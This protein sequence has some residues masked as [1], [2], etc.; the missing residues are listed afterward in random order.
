MSELTQNINVRMTHEMKKKIMDESYKRGISISAYILFLIQEHWERPCLVQNDIQ[1]EYNPREHEE[2][3]ICDKEYKEMYLEAEDE[4]KRLGI[5]SNRLLEILEENSITVLHP[6]RIG[7][8]EREKA[9]NNGTLQE[10]LKI[11]KDPKSITAVSQNKEQLLKASEKIRFIEQRLNSYETPVLK[12][13][14]RFTQ[15][16]V[17]LAPSIRDLPDVVQF[18]ANSYNQQFLNS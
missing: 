8:F 12:S 9:I 2:G 3:E 14:F 5:Y 18:L 4:I 6:K 17:S 1:G 16:Q 10:L 15:G 7:L 13:I 11:E